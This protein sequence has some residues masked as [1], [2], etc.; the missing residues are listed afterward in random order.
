MITKEIT[1]NKKIQILHTIDENSK[2]LV[3]VPLLNSDRYA[4]LY[5]LD[6]NE[7]IDLG[8]S[9][10]WKLGTDGVVHVS[11]PGRTNLSVARVITDAFTQ[12]VGYLNG[13]KTDLRRDNLVL[14]S[15]GRRAKLRARDL[16]VPVPRLGS[17]IEIEHVYKQGKQGQTNVNAGSVM[18]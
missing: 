3:K 15:N 16:I 13:D 14:D 4:T 7:L 9:S 5:E 18:S 8:L 2:G 10:V 1:M 11:V 17:K 6:F 12:R